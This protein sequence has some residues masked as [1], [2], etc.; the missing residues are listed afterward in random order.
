[1]ILEEDCSVREKHERKSMVLSS[2]VVDLQMSRLKY[3]KYIN[4]EISE[5]QKFSFK[6]MFED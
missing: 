5:I 6:A 1:M 3:L 2:S 4:A